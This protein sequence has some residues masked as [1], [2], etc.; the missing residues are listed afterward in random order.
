MYG[1]TI[2]F[3]DFNLFKGI[4]KSPWVG[5]DT[6]NEI[7]GMKDFFTAL[8]NTFMLNFLDLIVSFPAPIILALMLNEYKSRLV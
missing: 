1:V 8:K 4:N 2:A 7:F 3:K 5:F 6:F